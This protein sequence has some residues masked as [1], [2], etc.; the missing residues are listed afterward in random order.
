MVF[1]LR[2]HLGQNVDIG[3]LSWEQREKVLRLL[4]ARMNGYKM[5]KQRTNLAPQSK[6]LPA[7]SPRFIFQICFF[8]D[9]Y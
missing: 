9:R 6:Q 1:V 3:Q 8:D 7:I 2:S 5:H 4:F